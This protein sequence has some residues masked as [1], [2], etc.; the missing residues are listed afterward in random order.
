MSLANPT[1][2][3]SRAE[4]KRGLSQETEVRCIRLP[5]D[6]S[7]SLSLCRTCC[8]PRA[9]RR[10]IAPGDQASSTSNE[11]LSVR[12]GD[13]SKVVC[14]PALLPFFFLS[15]ATRLVASLQFGR[16]C[17]PFVRTVGR[18]ATPAAL[19]KKESEV[20]KESRSYCA[21]RRQ[22][23]GKE[24]TMRARTCR[25]LLR[26]DPHVGLTARFGSYPAV[27][28]AGQWATAEKTITSR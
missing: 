17:W 28:P 10:R 3:P 18:A 23:Y 24:K 5:F 1:G 25:V 14:F 13:V 6:P 11:R 7:L 16:R 15:V 26:I 9:T 20:L 2:V 19:E 22:V 4:D 12:C 21:E 8:L 27:L